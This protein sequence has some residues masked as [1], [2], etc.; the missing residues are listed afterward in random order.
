EAG[1]LTAV[2]R[3]MTAEYQRAC[4]LLDQ[5]ARCPDDAVDAAVN[6][7]C[8]LRELLAAGPPETP[9]D[10]DLLHQ[11]LGRLIAG[12]PAG[13]QAGIAGMHGTQTLGEI[14]HMDLDETEVQ[15]AL[16]VTQRVREVLR[17]DGLTSG[18]VLARPGGTP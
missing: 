12:P 13:T 1:R 10:P 6:A 18:A 16:A 8:M 11:A 15:L 17:A 5:V 2:P 4:R 7:L 14:V 9:L 3:L